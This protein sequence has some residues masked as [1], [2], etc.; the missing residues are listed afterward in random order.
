MPHMYIEIYLY[1]IYL[2]CSYVYS[3][4]GGGK[5]V[6]H[7][8]RLHCII[9]G[10]ILLHDNPWIVPTIHGLYISKGTRYKFSVQTS[11]HCWININSTY[12]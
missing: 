10:S 3:V 5:Y 1:I 11:D 7:K 8:P 4:C 12:S 6:L 2:Y 9:H